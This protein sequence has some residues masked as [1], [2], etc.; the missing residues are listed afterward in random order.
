MKSRLVTVQRRYRIDMEVKLD[1][2]NFIVKKKHIS[3]IYL[4]VTYKREFNQLAVISNSSLLWC[5]FGSKTLK[6]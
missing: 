1:I 3:S 4:V 6:I 2:L 5:A